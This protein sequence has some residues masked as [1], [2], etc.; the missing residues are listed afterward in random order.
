MPQ[1][2]KIEDFIKNSTSSNRYRAWEKLEHETNMRLKA[3][4]IENGVY[5][6]PFFVLNVGYFTYGLMQE[7][8]MPFNKYFNFFSFTYLIIFISSI[9]L[10]YLN[11]KYVKPILSKEIEKSEKELTEDVYVEGNKLINTHQ[12]NRCIDSYL[13]EETKIKN[14]EDQIFLIPTTKLKYQNSK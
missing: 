13:K 1:N 3:F 7:A 4:F 10:T 11:L 5:L 2:K 6:A 8:T 14:K 12:F 9:V